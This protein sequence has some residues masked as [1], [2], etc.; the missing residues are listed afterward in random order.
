M[1]HPAREVSRF[2]F[3]LERVESSRAA[4]NE[5]GRVRLQ[6]YRIGAEIEVRLQPLWANESRSEGQNPIDV[7]GIPSHPCRK[8]RGKDGVPGYF[9]CLNS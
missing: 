3:E 8:E 4:G 1:G 7:G 5:S 9:H 6:S 2:G